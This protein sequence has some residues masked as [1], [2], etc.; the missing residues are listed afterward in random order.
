MLWPDSDEA[1]ARSNLR[2]A[3]WKL[4]D[5]LGK[6]AFVA[7]KLNLSLNPE[8][9]VWVDVKVFDAEA[10]SSSTD[11]LLEAVQLYRGELLPGFYDDWAELERERLRS[12]YDRKVDQMIGGLIDEG[13]WAAAIQW[14]ERWIS[15]GHV[16][17]AAF[18]WLMTAHRA[19]GDT[20]RVVET[21]DR[22]ASV[23]RAELDVEPSP[24]TTQLL[25]Q[26][27]AASIMTALPESRGGPEP[28]RLTPR[29]EAVPLA[30][31]D[32]WVEQDGGSTFVGRQQQLDSLWVHLYAC[33]RGEGR[34][35][36]ITGQA[37]SGKTSLAT[38]FA[39][40][41][42]KGQVPLAAVRGNCELFT[43]S[44]SPF[45]PFRQA[46][47]GLL[48]PQS[49][50]AGAHPPGA[51]RPGALE[52]AV[53]WLTSRMNEFP[54]DLLAG[55]IPASGTRPM[56]AAAK[57]AEAL[58]SLLAA[59]GPNEAGSDPASVVHRNRILEAFG[60]LLEGFSARLPV[61]IV[62]DD[63]HWI[64]PSSAALLHYLATRLVRSPILLIGTYRPDE[65]LPS[66]DGSPH[67]LQAALAEI[68]RRYGDVWLDLEQLDLES[69][70]GFVSEMLEGQPLR[71]SEDFGD[72]LAKTTRGHPFFI[73]ELVRD[74]Q[75]RGGLVMAADGHWVE[76]EDL[77][78]EVMPTRVEAVVED[79]I[80]RLDV[81]LRRALSIA[82]VQGEEF[83][84][85]VVAEVQGVDP[86][87]MVRRM[88][89]EL[90]RQH[91]LLDE[92]RSERMGGRLVTIF[93]FR[94]VLIQ[95]YLYQKLG[96]GERA[97]LHEVVGNALESIYA[98]TNSAPPA[99]SLAR[100]FV[101]A[102]LD[103]K[104]AIYLQLAGEQALRVSAYPEAIDLLQ[105]AR[106]RL[107]TGE[108]SAGGLARA[109][110]E[111][112]LGEAVY[113][114]GDVA[115]SARHL[116]R[117]ARLL[118]F[119]IPSGNR[120]VALATAG[121]IIVQALHLLADSIGLRPRSILREDWRDAAFAHKLL[122]EI[123]LVRNETLLTLYATVRGLNLAEVSGAP[124]EKARA[125]ADAAVIAPLLKVT[126]LGEHYQRRALEAARL[127]EGRATKAY[128]QLS[129]SIYDLGEGKFESARQALEQANLV[130]AAL[131]DWSRLGVGL[132]LLANY[133][134]LRGENTESLATYQDLKSL[135]DKS[136]NLQH[137][138][139]GLDGVAKCLL[140]RGNQDAILQAI[141][142]LGQ[143]Q[144][145]LAGEGMLQEE[146]ELLGFLALAEWRLGH[147]DRALAMGRQA[148]D[149]IE[150]SAPNFFAQGEGYSSVAWTC[151]WAWESRR[152][153]S[154]PEVED[155]RTLSRTAV[156]AL[157]RLAGVCPVCL[158][159]ACIVRGTFEWVSGR[160]A[161]AR[162]LWTRGL[163]QARVLGMPL[164]Q[165]LAH[166]ELGRHLPA[167]APDRL[168]HVA[169]AKDWFDRLGMTIDPDPAQPSPVSL[170]TH[171]A[172]G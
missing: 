121:G 58:G 14:S 148:A 25:Q 4:G 37:G 169:Q 114:M 21:Y 104:A 156:M 113:G 152:T 54:S 83:V 131:G 154:A 70:R 17:E 74:L 145:I 110:L 155:L 31:S 81:E 84:A 97:Y 59:P 160:P 48:A 108:A 134:S 94:H 162:A 136:G 22:C 40:R 33:L 143:S 168:E 142:L 64:D 100:H 2:H 12:V 93:A 115:E 72:R 38:A 35:A 53:E 76:A 135:G 44:H 98:E 123:Y 90:G 88:T 163:A 139:W 75:E 86:G 158:P 47:S 67:P 92:V 105:Q 57:A 151:L 99:G 52:D 107:P 29:M 62:L 18:R 77:D 89:A 102:G 166:F 91:R 82:S 137:Q 55:M 39:R 116:E 42:L 138:A 109:R 16:P 50:L 165:A 63:L 146:V 65:L 103:Q 66:A 23:L 124:A 172:A 125:Y 56:S 85:E 120:R 164:D 24:E 1:N 13:Q 11:A 46:L 141:K 27:T 68:K 79:R 80:G 32:A 111:R 7:D 20:G 28:S 127:V 15:Q 170:E 101:E 30:P 3:L 171:D 153:R 10:P 45:A 95:R 9:A 128:V 112:L 106:D 147:A 19:L 43:G 41:A 73:L 6:R 36:L 150:R 87:A 78:L 119:P 49:S 157:D 133:H 26:L 96:R 159:R 129:T 61:L 69:A 130:H 144:T 140:R 132:M 5:A 51:G 118:G 60:D 34:I 8:A 161:R 126:R 122:A 149:I 117:A 71:V 167:E